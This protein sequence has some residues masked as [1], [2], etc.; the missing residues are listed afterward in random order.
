MLHSSLACAE[1]S[2]QLENIG[3]EVEYIT[4]YQGRRFGAVKLGKVRLIDNCPTATGSRQESH[5]HFHQE[6]AHP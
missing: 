2:D 3:F 1:I 5:I 4:E 6:G